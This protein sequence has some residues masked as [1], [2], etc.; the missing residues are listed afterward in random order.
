[1]KL[2]VDEGD[3]PY[4]LLG[5]SHGHCEPGADVRDYYVMMADGTEKR[6]CRDAVRR[7]LRH[8]IHD[9]MRKV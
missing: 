2:E 3:C 1:M 4:V 7:V 6:L 5:F 8:E 9:M